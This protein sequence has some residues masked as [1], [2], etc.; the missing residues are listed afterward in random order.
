MTIPGG[1]SW[2]C[3]HLYKQVVEDCTGK[4]RQLNEVC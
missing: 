3:M 4:E 2:N 1:C